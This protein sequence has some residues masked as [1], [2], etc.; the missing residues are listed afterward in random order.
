MVLPKLVA[1]ASSA[2]VG[3]VIAGWAGMLP[4]AASAQTYPARPLRFVVAFPA[5]SATDANARVV[6]HHITQRTGVAVVVE[7][8]AGANGFLAAEAVARSA[9]DGHTM[10]VTTQTTH[11]INPNVFKRLPYDPV[12]DFAPVAPISRGALLL[13]A[14]PGFPANN[15]AELTALA[16]ATPGKVS[17]ASGNMSSRAGGELYAAMA[18]VKLLH[19]PYKGAPQA[20]NDVSAGLVDLMWADA[21][22][23]SAQLRSGRVKA[24]GSTGVQR[25]RTAPGVPTMAEQGMAGFELYAWS[26]AYFPAHTPA[27]LVQQ[28]NHWILGAIQAEPSFFE[29]GGGSAFHLSP[30]EFAQFQAKEL[31]LWARIVQSAGIE[32]E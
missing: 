15:L 23:G 8:K 9:P 7:N 10:L 16:K 2:V 11:A 25:L 17:F 27:A 1:A 4:G 13:V 21:Y 31:A 5:G 30:A 24:L 12:K 29:S 19:V 14:A 26:A 6:A 20:L 18:G 28:M 32:P 3:V 22:T